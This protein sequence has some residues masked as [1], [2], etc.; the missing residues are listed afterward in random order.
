VQPRKRL[1]RASALCQLSC[2]S[3]PTI[4]PEYFFA[5]LPPKK[6][7]TRER[8]PTFSSGDSNSL[9]VICSVASRVLHVARNVV[10]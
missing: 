7:A 1:L 8:R 4:N 2:I 6:K 10:R 5:F 9:V 3:K